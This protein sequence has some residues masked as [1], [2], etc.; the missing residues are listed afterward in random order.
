MC[1][2]QCI[3]VIVRTAVTPACIATQSSYP[4]AVKHVHNSLFFRFSPL[5]LANVRQSPG[6]SDLDCLLDASAMGRKSNKGFWPSK[7]Y[8]EAG[9]WR[10][11]KQRVSAREKTKALICECWQEDAGGCLCARFLGKL[12]F[13][14]HTSHAR[15]TYSTCKQQQRQKLSTEDKR[16]KANEIKLTVNSLSYKTVNFASK[17]VYSCNVFL[18]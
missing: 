10:M 18:S 7:R 4:P 2:V 1:E 9:S 15:T 13:Y 5:N 12:F 8:S 3:M 14:S 16:M 11:G 6:F 17:H